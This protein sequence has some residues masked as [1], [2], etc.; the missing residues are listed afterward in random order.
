MLESRYEKPYAIAQS[1]PNK[2]PSYLHLLKNAKGEANPLLTAILK[3]D[4][5]KFLLQFKLPES[6]LKVSCLEKPLSF[7]TSLSHPTNSLLYSL[8]LTFQ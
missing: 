4:P 1:P 3:S 6:S 5:A 8:I 7:S 2:F